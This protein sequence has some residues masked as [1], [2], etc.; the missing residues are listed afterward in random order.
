MKSKSVISVALIVVVAGYFALGW[1]AA[2]TERIYVVGCRIQQDAALS[3]DE[4]KNQKVSDVHVIANYC[5]C[6]GK[7]FHLK[8]GKVRMALLETG[9]FG[10]ADLVKPTDDDEARCAKQATEQVASDPGKASV[11]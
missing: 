7:D 10:V 6:L 5:N 11:K 8:N 9:L 4:R 2:R 1:F 3:N